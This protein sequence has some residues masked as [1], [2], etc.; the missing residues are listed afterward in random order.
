MGS[1]RLGCLTRPGNSLSLGV[2]EL[3]VE[4]VSV[5]VSEVWLDSVFLNCY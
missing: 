2:Q 5:S 3:S 1:N 4:C